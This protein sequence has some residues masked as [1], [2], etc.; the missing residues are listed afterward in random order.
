[1]RSIIDVSSGVVHRWRT[2]LCI[3]LLKGYTGRYAAQVAAQHAAPHG[4]RGGTVADQGRRLK[5]QVVARIRPLPRFGRQ[6][7]TDIERSAAWYERVLGMQHQDFDP[8]QGK[9]RRTSMSFGHQK[10]NLR[11][12]TADKIDWFT[13][14]H[15]AAG[16]DDVCFLTDSTPEHV[17][18][19]LRQLEVTIE[20]GPV[21]KREARGMLQSVYCRDPNGSL[22]EIA[23]YAPASG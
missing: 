1:M 12:V 10:I 15:E 6:R 11:P 5:L 3:D 21:A 16:S 8:G 4:G 13:A 17:V 20:E 22:I 18:A 9:V 7:V 19:H 2:G 23:S 14:C